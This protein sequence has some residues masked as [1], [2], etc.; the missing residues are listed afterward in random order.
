[1]N[2][3]HTITIKFSRASQER[4]DAFI[5]A[6]SKLTELSFVNSEVTYGDPSLD[7]CLTMAREQGAI[8]KAWVREDLEA[9]WEELAEEEHTELNAINSETKAHIIDQAFE[10][11]IYGD[12][13]DCTDDDWIKV[14]MA[15]GEGLTAENITVPGLN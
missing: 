6:L 10:S 8:V 5:E 14:D 2:D 3:Q 15:I 12:L 9:R 1:M 4:V 11:G 13:S 7:E